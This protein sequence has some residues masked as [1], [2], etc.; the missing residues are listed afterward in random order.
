MS[1]VQKYAETMISVHRKNKEIIR[2]RIRD[3]IEKFEVDSI[4]DIV[5]L[6]ML[7]EEMRNTFHKQSGVE[8]FIGFYNQVAN[9]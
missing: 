8:S 6:D 2:Q 1:D 3:L 7:T 5:K 9:D 4:S